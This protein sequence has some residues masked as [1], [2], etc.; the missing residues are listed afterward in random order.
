VPAPRWE[1]LGK[2]PTDILDGTESAMHDYL[3]EWDDFLSH[4]D[5]AVAQASRRERDLFEGEIRRFGLGRRAMAEDER[6]NLAFRLT[7]RVFADLNKS[8][9][10]D[11]WRLFQ[12]VFIVSHLPALAAR[13][14]RDDKE[15]R[16]ELDY[17]DVLWFPTGGGKTEAYLGLIVCALFYD[18]LRGK[19]RGATAWLKFPLRMLSVQQLSRVLRVLVVAD[20]FRIE[21]LGDA[22]GDP[23]E[24]GYLVGG[25]NTP[26]SLIYEAEWWPGIKRAGSLDE[27]VLNEHRLVVECPFC[28]R[29]DVRLRF[30]LP[31]VRLIHHCDACGK[32]LPLHMTDD[33]VYRYMPSV[34][35]GTVDKLSGFAFYGE[36]T[37]FAHGPRFLC[38][39]HGWF[40]FPRGG[41]C[42]AGDSCTEK[43][44]VSETAARWHDP[45]PALV[46]QDEL[47]LLREE[48][49]AFDAHYEGLFAE[50][51]EGGPSGLPSKMLAASATIEQFED[52]LRQVYGRRP[53]SFPAPGFAR[54]R[55]F[56][57]VE[58]SDTRRV[59]LGVLPHYRRKADVAG[60]VQAELLEQVRML[61]DMAPDEAAAALGGIVDRPALARLLF[62]Y[63]VSLAYVNS[64]PNGDQIADE[65]ARL[66]ERFES[67]GGDR[68]FFRVLTGQVGISELAAAIDHVEQDKVTDPRNGR[69][70]ALV[71]TSVVSHGVDL[72]RLNVMT[73][74]GLPATVADYIQATSRS[75]RAHVGFVV[76]VF[77]AFSRRERS[78]FTNFFSFHRFLDRMV[79]PVPVNKYARFGADRTLPGIVMGL[80]WDLCRDDRLGGPSEG[81]RRTRWLSKWWNARAVDIKPRLE[82]RIE[83]AY[84]SRVAGVNEPSLEDELVERVLHRW[85]HVEMPTMQR[86]D[87]DSTRHLFR[88]RVL[89]SFRDIDLPVEFGARPFHF[90]EAAFESLTGMT[91]AEDEHDAA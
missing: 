5:A 83:R 21:E 56:Y 33:E 52:Q 15:F 85:T 29:R 38:P 80:L 90:N 41:K 87:A 9:D 8:A 49:G 26:N 44:Y 22:A 54:E 82:D 77:D 53:R 25:S 19:A 27:R 71:G 48:L 10:F 42:L 64:K 36:F 18:R 13:E 37:Q 34:V 81:I 63:E 35:V 30:D 73:L 59:F 45:V 61:Q 88:E 3:A 12:L 17:A 7:N 32:D 79:E 47:H 46:V 91:V 20:R 86:F 62:L 69:L 57:T 75:G 60:I 28:T 55:S 74:A 4:S 51:Q 58:T 40:T 78:T 66:S 72:S 1:E 24:L 39:T 70:Q 16:S 67:L 14:H 65:L 31:K 76:T 11:T 84:R 6:L 50:L 23:F 68:I 2:D 43:S 89:A